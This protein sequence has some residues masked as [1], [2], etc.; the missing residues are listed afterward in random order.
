MGLKMRITY[1]DTDYVF[2]IIDGKSINKYTTEFTI[3]FNG[4]QFTLIK[5]EK[6]IWTLGSGQTALSANFVLAIGRSVSL[7]YRM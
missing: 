6:N 1:Q 4:D 7:R 2:E 3:L 5:N